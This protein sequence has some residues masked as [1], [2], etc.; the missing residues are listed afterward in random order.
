MACLKIHND[1]ILLCTGTGYPH[2]K[3]NTRLYVTWVTFLPLTGQQ[4]S[5]PPNYK[6]CVRWSPSKF[7]IY[8]TQCY[9]KFWSVSLEHFL[10]TN[11]E[12][13]GSVNLWP[14]GWLSK[15]NNNLDLF[16]IPAEECIQISKY[17]KF[18]FQK[19]L[20]L[21]VHLDC[22]LG[23]LCPF[24]KKKLLLSSSPPFSIWTL[25]Y[26]ACSKKY[27]LF[28]LKKLYVTKFFKTLLHS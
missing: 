13:G 26:L 7:A 1:T 2:F 4:F 17:Y 5:T 12:I 24:F 19:N 21:A 28:W 9:G 6:V 11:S 3:K 14:H 20:L 22:F 15:K 18:F 25:L 10:S 16:C 27:L 8:K 23:S